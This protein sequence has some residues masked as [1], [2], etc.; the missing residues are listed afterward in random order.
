M[1]TLTSALFAPTKSARNA[2][3]K[4]QRAKLAV[5][6]ARKRAARTAQQYAALQKHRLAKKLNAK[7]LTK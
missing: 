4:L 3:A 1:K 7:V 6:A 5:V 2:A